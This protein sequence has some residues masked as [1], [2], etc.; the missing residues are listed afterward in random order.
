MDALHMII[1][2]CL[3]QIITAHRDLCSLYISSDEELTELHKAIF[4]SQADAED[5]IENWHIVCIDRAP[6]NGGK[7]H[8]LLGDSTTA[9]TPWPTSPLSGIDL[10]NHWAPT[11]ARLLYHIVSSKVLGEPPQHHVLQM[12][13]GLCSWRVGKFLGVFD[14]DHRSASARHD[15]KADPNLPQGVRP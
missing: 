8:V 2:H 13:R 9:R 6:A 4:A 12:C 10:G 15:I 7:A 11:E 3:D 1:P 14:P 5:T